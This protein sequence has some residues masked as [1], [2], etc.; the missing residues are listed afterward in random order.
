MKTCSVAIVA[1]S[2]EAQDVLQHTR[3]MLDSFAVPWVERITQ[4]R[5]ELRQIIT[6]SESAGAS[7]F[8][9]SNTSMDPLSVA[10]SAITIKPVL[11]VPLD[12]PE[13]SPLDAL[14]ASAREGTVAGT[15]AIGKAGAINAALLAV[16]ILANTNADLRARLERFRQEQTA[17]VLAEILQ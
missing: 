11:A 2:A 9:V 13:L 10:V 12:G 3:Q 17:K 6:E 7:V 8:I 4:N 5:A 1:E 16:A 15:L 14:R